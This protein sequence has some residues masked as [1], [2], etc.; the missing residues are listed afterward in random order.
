MNESKGDGV[1][2]TLVSDNFVT[3]RRNKVKKDNEGASKPAERL[4]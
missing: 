2:G 4:K 3:K 1:Y